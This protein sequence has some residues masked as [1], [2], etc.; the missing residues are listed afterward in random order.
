MDSEDERTRRLEL[1]KMV[2]FGGKHVKRT[3]F[4]YPLDPREQGDIGVILLKLK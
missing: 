1:T 3:R 4:Q 2:W